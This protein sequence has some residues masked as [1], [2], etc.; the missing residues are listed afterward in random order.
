ML[1]LV[2]I[3]LDKFEHSLY[4]TPF[5]FLNIYTLLRVFENVNIFA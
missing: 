1:Q 2:T 4:I 5:I 3:Y